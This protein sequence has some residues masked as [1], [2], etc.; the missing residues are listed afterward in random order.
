MPLDLS[1]A[2]FKLLAIVNR[3]D[4]RK[5]AAYG[6]GSGGE[7]RLMFVHLRDGCVNSNSQPFDVILEFGV[8][9][10]GCL[11]VKAW[12]NQWKALEALPPGSSAYNTALEALTQQVVVAN[13]AS[14]RPNGSA[15]SQIRTNET[16]L[17]S[18]AGLTGRSASSGSIR[19]R[20]CSSSTRWRRRL[21][22]ACTPVP[23]PRST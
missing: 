5:Q 7:L 3:V 4:L 10:S 17:D 13:A 16:R 14:G 22:A 23:C 8:P 11:S 20:T 15:L 18:L 6:G 21:S 12:A 19:C 9:A 2:P 1:K